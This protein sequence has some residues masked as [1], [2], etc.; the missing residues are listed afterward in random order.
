MQLP[1]EFPGCPHENAIDIPQ[2]NHPPGEQICN[3]CG[4]SGWYGTAPRLIVTMPEASS[5]EMESFAE[6]WREQQD[7]DYRVLYLGEDE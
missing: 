6:R 1:A 5:E 7:T 2:L 3:D 4:T